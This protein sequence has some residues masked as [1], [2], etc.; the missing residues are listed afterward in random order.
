MFSSLPN[1][2]DS[3]REVGRRHPRE[4]ST[5][6][7][8][9]VEHPSTMADANG[10]HG[11]GRVPERCLKHLA[12]PRK[13]SSPS[14]EAHPDALNMLDRRADATPGRRANEMVTGAPAWFTV[15]GPPFL[16]DNGCLRNQGAP[17]P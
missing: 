10:N 1:L 15:C 8:T 14:A 16:N 2:G 7:Y 17:P 12:E 3:A 6:D 13:L 11:K 9:S 5:V 4:S